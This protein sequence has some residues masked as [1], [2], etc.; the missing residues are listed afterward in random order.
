MLTLDRLQSDWMMSTEIHKVEARLWRVVR[1]EK[2]R[3]I[4]VTSACRSEGKSTTA[5]FLATVN[6]Q[7]P[8]R[9]V[10]AIDMDLRRPR[11]NSLLEVPGEGRLGDVLRGECSVDDAIAPSSVLGLDVLYPQS[12]GEDPALLLNT[13]RVHEVMRGGTS[14]Y[15]LVLVDVPALLPVQDAS[16]LLPLSDGVILVTMAG[17]TTRH[18]LSKARELCLGLGVDVIGLIVGNIKEADPEYVSYGY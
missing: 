4:V 1:D 11:L 18:Q 13:P 2:R 12:E 9:R 17:K 3:V 16:L 15:D 6:G 10:L 14:A 8:D 7:Y 5:A